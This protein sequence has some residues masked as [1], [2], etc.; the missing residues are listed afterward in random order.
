[1]NLSAA[2]HPAKQ[3]VLH[4]C[5]AERGPNARGETYMKTAR[6]WRTHGRSARD[7]GVKP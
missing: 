1:M 5:A 3:T 7:G 4:L 2:L 6:L